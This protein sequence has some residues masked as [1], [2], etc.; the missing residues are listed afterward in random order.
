MSSGSNWLRRPRPRPEALVQ[1][2]C[3]PHAGAGAS[4]YS[5]WPGEL[6]E[7]DVLLAQ[8]PGRERRIGEPIPDD[9]GQMA[10]ELGDS[11]PRTGKPL[12]VFGHSLGALLA[13]ELARKLRRAAETRLRRLVV[14]GCRAPSDAAG[15]DRH[16]LPDGDLIEEMR[17]LGGTPE[18]VFE[19]PELLEL[20][21]PTVRADF[22]L[23]ENYIPGEE[24]PL[25]VPI[26]ALAGDADPGAPPAAVDAWREETT[27]TFRCHIVSGDHF[28]VDSERPTVLSHVR[29][30]INEA[31]DD[32]R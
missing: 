14:S 4:A 12:V 23:A 9:L 16:R 19:H 26:V 2:L 32:G 28:F 21:L 3:L 10:D 13:F 11:L 1:L 27:K 29:N 18:E 22:A 6:P 20:I 8:L 5:S 17:Q 31:R 30:A 7:A 24:Q 15:G 25:D